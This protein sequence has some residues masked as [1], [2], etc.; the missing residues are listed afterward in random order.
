MLLMAPLLF[1]LSCAPG[2]YET[3]PAYREEP[4]QEKFYV[5]P[6]TPEEE[7]YRIWKESIP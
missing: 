5:N 2:Y 1:L 6:E 4:P 7:T 3:K